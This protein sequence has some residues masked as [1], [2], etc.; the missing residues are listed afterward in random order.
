MISM[1]SS[2]LRKAKQWNSMINRLQIPRP[3]GKGTMN[4]AMFWTAYKLTTV[5]QKDDNGYL[6]RLE[7]RN[8]I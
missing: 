3:D 7:Y 6:V 4:P 5:P 1:A 2:Q 8:S